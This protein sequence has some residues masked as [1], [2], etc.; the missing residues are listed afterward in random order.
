MFDPVAC[1]APL[2]SRNIFQPQ[3]SRRSLGRESAKKAS[4][5][6][7]CPS[8]SSNLFQK[9]EKRGFPSAMWGQFTLSTL[10]HSLQLKTPRIYGELSRAFS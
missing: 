3:A 10:Q 8:K 6:K 1:K 7:M 4:R 2:I 9:G 5:T